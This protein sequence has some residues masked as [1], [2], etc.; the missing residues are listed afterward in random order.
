MTDNGRRTPVI[1]SATRTPIGKYL[2]A[3]S[4][5]R[6]PQLGA[7]AVKEAV[8]RAGIDPAAVEEVILGNVVQGGEGQAPAR[9]A[10][11]AGDEQCI[12]AGGMESMSTAPHYLFGLRNGVKFG[13]QEVLD[14]TIHDGLWCS[15]GDCHMGSYA[16][17]TAQ[18]AGVTR[19]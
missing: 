9:Q 7:I 3:L 10:A 19:E 14:G 11:K 1:V 18:K 8:K 5:L 17:Y 12:V 4:S 15:F 6:A 13:N 16:E 2:G